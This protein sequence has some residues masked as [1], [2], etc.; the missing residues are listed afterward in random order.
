LVFGE[1]LLHLMIGHGGITERNVRM[2]WWIM[3]ALMGLM[4]G[5]TAGQ[6]TAVAFSAMGDTKTP[7]NLFV[8]TF[9]V[10]VPIK[11]FAFLQYGLMGIAL[12]T[13]VHLV[14]NFLVQLAVLERATSPTRVAALR[15]R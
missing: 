7:T 15:V 1:P 8:F 10:Y 9:T 6:V 2:L 14:I 5:G 11:V 3:L 13:S 4:L 12:A